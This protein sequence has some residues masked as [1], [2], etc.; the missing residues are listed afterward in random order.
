MFGKACDF[1]V[2]FLNIVGVAFFNFKFLY[3]LRSSV[4][5][6]LRNLRNRHVCRCFIHNLLNR[7]T[8]LISSTLRPSVSLY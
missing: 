8:I 6:L 5:F 1:I 4:A 7:L 3:G 2:L